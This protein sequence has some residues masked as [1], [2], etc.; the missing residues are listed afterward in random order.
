MPNPNATCRSPY[1]GRSASL[2]VRPSGRGNPAKF[3]QAGICSWGLLLA[4]LIFL[5]TPLYAFVPHPLHML[6]LM[7]ANSGKTKTAI[8]EQ[9]ITLHGL[10]ADAP[11]RILKG[12]L[13]FQW[14]GGYRLESVGEAGHRVQVVRGSDS[15]IIRDGFIDPGP[16]SAID[17]YPDLFFHRTRAGMARRLT[18]LGID[19]AL[20]SPGLWQGHPHWV[21]GAH[22]PDPDKSQV[23]IHKDNFRPL[24]WRINSTESQSYPIWEI[25]YVNWQQKH[26]FRYPRRINFYQD[27]VLLREIE[28]TEVT[29][30]S[31]LAPDLL[32]L[33]KLRA[34][35]PLRPAGGADSPAM[36]EVEQV[37]EDFSRMYRP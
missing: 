1:S 23:W 22:Y 16:A 32:D 18:Q 3:Q 13:Y 7:L 17:L 9:R 35:Y 33:E 29:I 37:L 8:L 5:S 19:M 28:I 4:G 6:D 2:G 20:A 12:T 15:L 11:R 25:E 10:E 14:P 21:L 36:G 34:Q 27:T 31:K 30:N 24:G 26:G